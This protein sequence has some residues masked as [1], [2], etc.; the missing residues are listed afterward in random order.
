MGCTAVVSRVIGEG[1]HEQARRLTTHGMLLS[2]LVVATCTG[3][4]LLTMNPV[5]RMLG[6]TPETLPMIRD[7]MTI[8][9]CG[10]VFAII[11]M[12]LNDI[13]RAA[14]R[15]GFSPGCSWRWDP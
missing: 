6:A 3:A 11:P 1:D 9:Y 8:W 4:G 7:Y 5:F 14:G 10:V 2:V 13:L 15:Q 12:T